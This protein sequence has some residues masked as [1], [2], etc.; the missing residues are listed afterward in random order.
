MKLFRIQIVYSTQGDPCHFWSHHNRSHWKHPLLMLS[1]GR[2]GKVIL[3]G[4]SR[5]KQKLQE[6]G[7]TLWNLAS[8]RN[9]AQPQWK[10]QKRVQLPQNLV[11]LQQRGLGKN[12]GHLSGFQDRLQDRPPGHPSGI[13]VKYHD[14]GKLWKDINYFNTQVCV[15]DAF[16]NL[17]NIFRLKLY[18][19]P[20]TCQIV[21]FFLF[22][23]LIF[24]ST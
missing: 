12:P 7:P 2:F 5:G 21:I 3:R 13:W 16:T 18:V 20:Q 15:T 22:S 6:A 19:I 11:L 17:G 8:V 9:P 10:S 1:V 14:D 23:S 24:N 4:R